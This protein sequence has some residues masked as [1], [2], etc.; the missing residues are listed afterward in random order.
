MKK[1]QLTGWMGLVCLGN[2][3]FCVDSKK[4]VQ[5]QSQKK[6]KNEVAVNA[7]ND[8]HDVKHTGTETQA[9]PALLPGLGDQSTTDS[10]KAVDPKQGVKQEKK[11][12]PKKPPRLHQGLNSSLVASDSSQR[13][14]RCLSR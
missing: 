12:A 7:S 3:T 5:S 1:F 10:E 9:D 13:N 11:I 14:G 4:P 2:A 6:L 8:L